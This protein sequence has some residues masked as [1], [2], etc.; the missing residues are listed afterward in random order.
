MGFIPQWAIGVGV[1]IFAV[2]IA[3]TL[4]RMLRPM[5]DRTVGRIAATSDSETLELRQAVDALQ[6]RLGE[7]EERLDFAERLLTKHREAD[8]L[9]S[10]PR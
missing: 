4:A 2:A 6:N 8:R 10:P 7:V 5:A 1:I 3:Q 9:G